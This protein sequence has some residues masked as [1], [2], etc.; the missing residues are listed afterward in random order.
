MLIEDGECAACLLAGLGDH[1]AALGRSLMSRGKYEQREIAP[2]L[3]FQGL[4]PGMWLEGS[5]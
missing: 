5:Q 4:G 3:R 1:W 2:E